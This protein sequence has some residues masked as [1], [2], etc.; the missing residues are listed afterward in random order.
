MKFFPLLSLVILA[1]LS[2]SAFAESLAPAAPTLPDLDY[3]NAQVSIPA[4]SESLPSPNCSDATCTV[5]TNKCVSPTAP[6]TQLV[7]GLKNG[8]YVIKCEC[9]CS[10]MAPAK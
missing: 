4:V 1:T 9:T 10:D 7:Q 2:F 6:A 8:N 3:C 5:T